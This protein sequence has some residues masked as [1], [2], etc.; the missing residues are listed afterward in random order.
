MNH[1][2]KSPL[3]EGFRQGVNTPPDMP[4]RERV[5]VNTFLP[6][7][8]EGARYSIEAI[9]AHGYI[10]D[11][12]E[13]RHIQE[14]DLLAC[15]GFG[16]TAMLEAWVTDIIGN[17][18]GDMLVVGQT[19]DMVKDWMESRMRKVLLASPITAPFVPVGSERSNWKKDSVIFRHMNF[20]AG[21]ANTTD[22]QEKSMVYTAGDEAW[23]WD[24]GMI[25]Y[26]RKR[27]HGRWN[28]KSLIMSQGGDEGTEWHQDAIAGKWH[29]FH[30]RC[31]SCE[32]HS[33]FDWQNFQ[34]ETIRDSNDELDWP[35]IYETVRLVC[36]HCK[37]TFEDT[38][39]NRRQWSKCRP[40]WNGN[41]YIP[42][43]V[44]F[45]ASFLTVWRYQW[46][47]IVKEWIVANEEKRTG[48]LEKIRNVIHQRFAQFWKPPTETPSLKMDGDPYTKKE[49]H[50]GQKWENEAFRFLTVDVQKG[51]FWGVVRAWRMS[52]ESRQL[53]E[54]R[55]ETWEAIRHTQ[56][57]YGIENRFVFVDG[58]YIPE[59]VAREAAKIAD[60]KQAGKPWVILRG[61]E[62]R[63]GYIVADRGKRFRRLFS[64]YV[65]SRDCVPSYRYIRF[66]NLLAKDRLA[67]LMSGDSFG[68]PVDASKDYHKQMQSETKREVT[69]GV[70]RWVPIK[71]GFPNHLWDCEVMQVTGASIYG[72]LSS[73][74][75]ITE[76]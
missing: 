16:K 38:E 13:D 4:M 43:R 70:W 51:H 20:F 21:A 10:F 62:A 60:S 14:V 8:P 42:G 41:K 3:I 26:L 54:G 49:Y 74:S 46:R 66:S 23:R 72:I 34:Y 56:E 31:P 18:P 55:L 37:E 33:T 32:E 71:Q 2:C 52:G 9:P 19:R 59:T 53:W 6:N 76:K 50:D 64:N 40:V 24:F 29:D 63:D 67:G 75:E 44:T 17:N 28:R 22:T 36:P 73:M 58:G 11:A 39:Y 12:L 27:H 68:I 45:A 69:P 5:C 61:E 57:R 7:S 35:A 15:V 65:I 25:D 48:Q 47:D 1:P 30:H